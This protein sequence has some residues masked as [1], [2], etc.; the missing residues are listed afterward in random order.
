MAVKKLN[1]LPLGNA[2]IW[3]AA[4]LGTAIVMH[5]SESEGAVLLI[6]GGAAGASTMLVNAALRRG[7]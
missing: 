2:L 3:A 6:L 7:Q 1:P 5:W 4:I